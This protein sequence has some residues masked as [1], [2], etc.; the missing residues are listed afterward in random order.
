[1]LLFDVAWGGRAAV[2]EGYELDFELVGLD[3]ARHTLG[4]GAVRPFANSVTWQQFDFV[5]PSGLA[6]GAYELVVSLSDG[7]GESYRL[8]TALVSGVDCG[9]AVNVAFGDALRLLA[10]DTKSGE[11]EL[12]V[13]L[14]WQSMRAITEEYI[15]FVHV[16][17]LETGENVAQSDVMPRNWQYPTRY[18]WTGEVVADEVVVSM[19]G[20][21]LGRYGLAVGVYEFG[22]ADRLVAVDGA[23]EVVENGRLMLTEVDWE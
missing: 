22:G 18:W 8:A 1:L 9:T 11:G 5:V 21:Q 19:D 4:S 13:E 10:F 16:F 15:I 12:L 17:D 2:G 3:G 20:V 14:D 7:G 23:G 6:D